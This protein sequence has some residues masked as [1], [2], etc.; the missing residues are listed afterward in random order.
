[1]IL[2]SAWNQPQ[3]FPNVF[4]F[5]LQE[6][7]QKFFKAFT[8]TENENLSFPCLCHLY[9]SVMFYVCKSAAPLCA[10]A[11]EC[12]PDMLMHVCSHK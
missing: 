7:G 12:A 6:K 2:E 1:M 8:K 3:M 9:P 11:R 10:R 4:W 5:V